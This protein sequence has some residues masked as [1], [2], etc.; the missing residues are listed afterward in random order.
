MLT[1]RIFIFLINYS[2]FNCVTYFY[3][4]R[5]FNYIGSIFKV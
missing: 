2:Y 5:F 4:V 1:S 3:I